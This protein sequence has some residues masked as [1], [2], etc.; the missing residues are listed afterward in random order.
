MID[1]RF[2]P[3]H[4]QSIVLGGML[5]TQALRSRGLR[6]L[7]ASEFA[8]DSWHLA[9]FRG[10]ESAARDGLPEDG[11][12]VLC[13]AIE[14]ILESQSDTGLD[15]REIFRRLADLARNSPVTSAKNPLFDY[16]AE[17]LLARSRQEGLLDAL[18][19]V[20]K[21]LDEKTPAEAR[22]AFLEAAEGLKR[23]AV[24]RVIPLLA[25]CDEGLEE[26][27]HPRE[28]G[29]M[30]SGFRWFDETFGGFRRGENVVVAAATGVGKTALAMN[31]VVNIVAR[32]SSRSIHVISLE[33]ER[34]D[35]LRRLV[36]ISGAVPLSAMARD[37]KSEHERRR[38]ADAFATIMASKLSIDDHPN[39][40]TESIRRGVLAISEQRGLDYLVID[41]LQLIRPESPKS[42]RNEQVGQ[43]SR[44]IKLLAREAQCV[45]LNLCQLNR[46]GAKG[47]RPTM[48]QLRDSG[49]LENDADMV[50]LLYDPD[51]NSKTK[52]PPAESRLTLDVAK[53]RRGDRGVADLRFNKLIQT[54][55]EHFQDDDIDHWTPPKNP[56]GGLA[57]SY[58]DYSNI[59]S[60]KDFA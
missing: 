3:R 24:S 49:S 6:C 5:A 10:L 30:P 58:S 41:Y 48:H 2:D 38:A 28:S 8:D 16:H 32:D 55:D 4:S 45:A 56:Q 7:T 29:F 52:P 19:H 36:A 13:A 54:I 53:N 46:E 25:E 11:E 12:S 33:M 40:T 43:L 60:R 47:E 26:V 17:S 27:L 14:H 59:D 44:D 34:V 21:I 18:G 51:R 57:Y 42:S 39:H 9:V 31:L 15:R 22:N 1:R 35:L 37:C 20:R 50:L 23:D